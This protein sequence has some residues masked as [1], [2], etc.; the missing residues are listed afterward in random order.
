MVVRGVAALLTGVMLI[1]ACGAEPTVS[2]AQLATSTPVP[3]ATPTPEPTPDP[4]ATPVPTATPQPTAT[5]TPGPTPTPLPTATPTPIPR[6]VHWGTFERFAVVEGID[7]HYPAAQVE[8]VGFHE[9]GHD[10]SKRFEADLITGQWTTLNSRERDT[11]PHSAADVVV[12]PDTEIRAPVSGRVISASTYVL[13]CQYS[14]DL[15]YIEPD[16]HPGWQVRIFHISG[17]QVQ[18]GDRVEAGVTPIAPAATILP[19]PSQVDGVTAEPSWPHVHIEIV[20][21]SIP[22]RPTHTPGC[23]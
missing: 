7:V 8:M 5:P 19:F 16:E 15:L 3:T 18:V 13:Y 23:D 17:L 11:D 1:S 14:D 20:D 6:V 2:A 21:P 4:T 22:D 10:G 12:A 9:S